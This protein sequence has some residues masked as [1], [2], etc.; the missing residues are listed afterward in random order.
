MTP[1]ATYQERPLRSFCV[2]TR[3]T[4]S[5]VVFAGVIALLLPAS[6]WQQSPPRFE[7][8]QV[9]MG[10]PVRVVLYA[11]GEAAAREAA[12]AAFARIATLDRAMSDYRPDSEISEVARRA[13]APVSVSPDVFRVVARAIDIARDTDGAFD[14]T[15]APLVALWRD[16]RATGRLPT[17]AAI[18]TA[19]ALTGWRGVG[20]DPARQTIRLA[21]PGMRLDLGGVAKG[22]ILQAALGTL[23]GL[24]IRAAL[25]EAGGDIVAGDAPPGREGWRIEKELGGEF[26]RNQLGGEKVE[27]SRFA[28]ELIP[29]EFASELIAN[30]ALATSGPSAQFVEIDGVRHSHV[31]DPRTGWALTSGLTAHV[32]A[33]DAALADALATAATVTGMAGLERLRSRFPQARIDL[34]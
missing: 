20:L 24:G 8:S 30:T 14:P 25:L 3:K 9:H 34:R 7:Y 13:P 26:A 19:R 15:V 22:Y 6:V 32:I 5:E 31:V 2:P 4:T 27:S 10:V 28:S 17:R 11:P 23:R 16:A 29:R 33:S 18:D 12:A 1:A 21:T